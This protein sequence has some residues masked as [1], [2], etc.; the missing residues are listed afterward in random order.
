VAILVFQDQRVLQESWG[1][2]VLKELLVPLDH[3][4]RQVALGIMANPEHLVSLGQL[5]RWERG[6]LLARRACKDS[7]DHL[8]FLACQE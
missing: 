6:V 5:A 2:V 1:S 8:A 7:L 4:E 3:L